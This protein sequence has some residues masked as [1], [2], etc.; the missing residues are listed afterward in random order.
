M[1][2]LPKRVA[3]LAH[4]RVVSVAAGYDYNDYSMA[5]TAYG[6][7]YSWGCGGCGQLGLGHTDDQHLAQRVTALA[8]EDVVGISAGG[9]HAL[10]VTAAGG[11]WAWGSGDGGRLGLGHTKRQ[12]LPAQVVAL[13]DEYVACVEA[14]VR[15]S[16]AITAGGGLFSWG[17]W[18]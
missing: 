2:R 3:A 5:L 8:E 12:C 1:Q 4:V 14:G 13:K 10:A 9:L 6:T 11:V 15:H 18:G 7:V 17:V 16:F